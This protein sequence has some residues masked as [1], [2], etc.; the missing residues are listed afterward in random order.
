MR[1]INIIVV[2]DVW[3]IAYFFGSCTEYCSSCKQ[4][5]F[6]R[7]QSST[8]I[9]R[10]SEKKKHELG[11]QHETHLLLKS[12]YSYWNVFYS[13]KMRNLSRNGNVRELNG[14]NLVDKIITHRFIKWNN[15][16]LLEIYFVS[17][18]IFLESN[19]C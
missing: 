13:V 16:I 9:F 3:K 1:P 10:T 7:L 15:M 17:L 6:S 2:L 8:D 5:L 4:A 14:K 11:E 18:M 12:H 19:K